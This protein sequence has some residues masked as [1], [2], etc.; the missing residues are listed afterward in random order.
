MD[1]RPL[2]GRNVRRIRREQRLTQEQL[3]VRCGH[4]Q[5]YISELE[6]GKQNATLISIA[7]IAGALGVSHLELF[8]PN[9]EPERK[10]GR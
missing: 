5:Q 1:L 4:P 9:A 2:V 3:A 7:E 6:R 8:H 10:K